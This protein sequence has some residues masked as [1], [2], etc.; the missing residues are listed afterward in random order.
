MINRHRNQSQLMSERTLFRRGRVLR[1]AKR[2]ENFNLVVCFVGG[3]NILK[4]KCLTDINCE[5][6][7]TTLSHY[8][9]VAM[10]GHTSFGYQCTNAWRIWRKHQTNRDK[11]AYRVSHFEHE[12][13]N[14][15]WLYGK[16][17]HIQIKAAASSPFEFSTRCMTGAWPSLLSKSMGTYAGGKL[18]SLQREFVSAS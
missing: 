4:S 1:F 3:A 11:T 13:Q 5:W 14:R 18:T 15:K 17:N 6:S 2:R 10:R 8:E 12:L 9:S 16:E 7:H